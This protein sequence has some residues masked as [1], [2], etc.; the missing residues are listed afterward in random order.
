MIVIICSDTARTANKL[1]EY[2]SS[3]ND[4]QL[5]AVNELLHYLYRTCYLSIEYGPQEDSNIFLAS[6]NAV[7]RD[8]EDRKSSE[9]LLIRL[10][11]GPLNW[12]AGKQ[13]TVTTL[14]TKAELLSISHIAWEV[15]R[16]N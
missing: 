14:I 9:G 13:K 6:S 2:N 3:P 4:K 1:L 11:G 10:F 8:N 15:V 7:F 5:E 12:K 16:W